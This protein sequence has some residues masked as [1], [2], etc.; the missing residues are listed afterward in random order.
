MRL[1]RKSSRFIAIGGAIAA[2]IAMLVGA[3]FVNNTALAS[4][5]AGILAHQIKVQPNYNLNVR[6]S[7]GSVPHFDCQDIPLGGDGRC[8]IPQQIRAAYGIQPLLNKGINGKGTTI[9]IVDAFSNPYI[10][11]DLSVFDQEFG[12]PD[13]QFQVIAPFG[14]TPFDFN[15]ADQVNWSGEISLDVQWAHA[16]APNAK[17]VL[18]LAKTDEDIDIYNTTKYVIDHNV[19]DVISQ[20]FGEAESCV[21][22]NLLKQQHQMFV[23]ATRK[24]ITLIA[25]SGDDGAA[26]PTCDGNSLFLSASSPATDPLVLSVG[27]TTLNADGTTGAYIGETAWA[28][29]FAG[30]PPPDQGCSGGGFSNLYGRPFYQ[31]GVAGTK[32]GH[33][34]VPDVAYNAGVD[35]GVLTHW[36]VGLQVFVGLDPSTPAFFAFGGTSSGSPQ[37]AGL[38]ALGDQLAHHRLGFINAAIYRANLIPALYKNTFHDVT[39]GTNSLDPVTGYNAAKGW[40]AVTGW[41]SPKANNELPTLVVEDFLSDGLSGINN[42]DG[43]HKGD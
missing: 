4:S 39:V 38:T 2:V 34:G 11:T 13:P 40:D 19:G 20:S 18:A 26:Q 14:T 7:H 16:V 41:G 32:K 42:N 35:G 43:H 23:D 37:W 25:S 31:V 12:L 6:V 9:V 33:R 8:Y 24:N 10:Q 15:D 27:G 30:C 28:D 3:F 29:D 1:T 17:I 22:P 5:P 21:D 36:G